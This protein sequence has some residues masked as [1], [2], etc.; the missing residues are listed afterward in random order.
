MTWTKGYHEDH[1]AVLV[2]L[3]KLEGNLKDL[4]KGQ[5]NCGINLDFKEFGDIIK[6]VIIPHFKKEE[7]DVYPQIAKI[8]TT[9]EHIIDK[10]L[11]EHRQLY[12]SFGDYLQAI[13]ET[14]NQALIRSG[15]EI[16]RVLGHHIH[17]EEELL[18]KLIKKAKKI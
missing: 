9:S 17:K 3:A 7:T 6:T 10:M 13:D 1:M 11:E 2:L 16:L 12:D 5:Y 8:D 15:H 18:P 4:E 14:D